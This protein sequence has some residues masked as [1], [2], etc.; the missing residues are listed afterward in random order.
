M[1]QVRKKKPKTKSSMADVI[2]Q[3]LE[4]ADKSSKTRFTPA[5]IEGLYME[6]L[7]A[8][9]GREPKLAIT[10]KLLV[11]PERREDRMLHLDP[12]MKPLAVDAAVDLAVQLEMAATQGGK[13]KFKDWVSG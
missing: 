10:P 4:M 8:R 3:I 9:K 13:L 2:N 1:V 12:Q 11:K 5:H 6:G 7:K